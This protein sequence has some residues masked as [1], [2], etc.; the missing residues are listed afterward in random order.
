MRDHGLSDLRSMTGH[1]HSRY[2]IA[3]VIELSKASS[4]P[5][6]FLTNSLHVACVCFVRDTATVHK[7]K[8]KKS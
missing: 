4:I 2:E 3:M 1:V 7:K 8:K 5:P 6:V